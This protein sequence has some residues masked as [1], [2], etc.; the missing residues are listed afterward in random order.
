MDR[1]D[2]QPVGITSVDR[3]LGEDSVEHAQAAPAEN[4]VVDRPVRAIGGRPIA[5]ARPFPDHEDD[6]ADDPPIIDPRN[7]RRKW[8]IGLGSGLID[9][10][11]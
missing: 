5:P 8:R 9:H 2:H 1:V 11:Q 3:Q 4:A 6:T 7:A 10:N